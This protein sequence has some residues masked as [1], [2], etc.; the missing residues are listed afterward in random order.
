MFGT[1]GGETATL[2]LEWAVDNVD[3][4]AWSLVALIKAFNTG[5]PDVANEDILI[6]IE[7]INTSFPNFYKTME[8]L[9]AKF[10]K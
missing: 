8:T 4:G 7:T 1:K 3:L 5:A 2:P 9:G 6:D 10:K